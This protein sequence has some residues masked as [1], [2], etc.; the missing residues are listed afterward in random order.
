MLLTLKNAQAAILLERVS[1]LG[2]IEV[3]STSDKRSIG[4][5]NFTLYYLSF[6]AGFFSLIEEKN[7]NRNRLT[8]GDD[9]RD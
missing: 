8:V 5:V 3:I 4:G 9:I 7:E 1:L 2:T 6:V